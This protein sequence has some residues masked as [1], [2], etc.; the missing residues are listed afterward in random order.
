MVNKVRN[1]SNPFDSVSPIVNG[2]AN[3]EINQ[4]MEVYAKLQECKIMSIAR[5]HSKTSDEKKIDGKY[6]VMVVTKVQWNNEDI[7]IPLI[8]LPICLIT[9]VTQYEYSLA[10]IMWDYGFSQRQRQAFQ[11]SFSIKFF[12]I[13]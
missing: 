11:V 2:E 7:D 9:H 5:K 1:G 13:C 4:N 12:F 8:S 3:F 10:R 6:A